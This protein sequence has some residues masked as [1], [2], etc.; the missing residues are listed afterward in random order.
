M[1]CHDSTDGTTNKYDLTEN[2]CRKGRSKNKCNKDNRYGEDHLLEPGRYELKPSGHTGSAKNDD[3]T[4]RLKK[5]DPVYT[6]PYYKNG[7]VY[8]GGVERDTIYPHMG[9]WSDGCPLFAKDKEGQ[10][11]KKDFDR[12]FRN[13]VNNGGSDVWVQEK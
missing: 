8:S 9:S 2:A 12:R 1:Y 11:Q 3:G 6:T 10:R 7:W 4:P 13:N 5:G